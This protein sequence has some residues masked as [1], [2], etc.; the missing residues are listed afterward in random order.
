MII[1]YV[2]VVCMQQQN[3]GLGGG[4]GNIL[5]EGRVRLIKTVFINTRATTKLI[6]KR[7][8]ILSS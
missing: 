2:K 1:S 3:K 4:N 6:S 8:K 5:F 7:G